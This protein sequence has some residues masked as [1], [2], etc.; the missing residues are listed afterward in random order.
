MVDVA[1]GAPLIDVLAPPGSAAAAADV[2]TRLELAGG[3]G[4]RVQADDGTMEQSMLP[5][6]PL[7][8]NLDRIWATRHSPLHPGES[9]QESVALAMELAISLQAP[10]AAVGVYGV[11]GWG[12]VLF[13]EPR[14]LY[15][16]TLLEWLYNPRLSAVGEIVEDDPTTAEQE[17]RAKVALFPKLWTPE[18]TSRFVTRVPPG[19]IQAVESHQAL[20]LLGPGG[21]FDPRYW[22]SFAVQMALAEVQALAQKEG[23]SP[24]SAPAPAPATAPAAPAPPAP[25]PE[26]DDGL[27]PLQRARRKAELAAA[28][29]AERGEAAEAAPVVPEV[30]PEGPAVRWANGPAGPVLVIPSDRFDAGFVRAVQG[31]ST[32]ALGR[33]ERPDGRTFEQWVEAGGPFVTEVPFLSRLFLENN[34]LHKQLFIERST[35]EGALRVLDCH[36]PRVSRV[37]AVL[38]PAGDAPRRIVVSS[39]RDLTGAQIVALTD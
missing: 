14:W 4:W 37:R 35:E 38:V 27:T 22:Q 12:L 16:L 34:P 39:A 7:R 26:P 6:Q 33:D 21:S 5:S 28:E 1:R 11:V 31:G 10:L 9:M 30:A 3:G 19:A 18:A 24:A 32:D 29:A 23:T 8:G 36:L 20:S 25:P 15:G 2:Q 13:E 17:L